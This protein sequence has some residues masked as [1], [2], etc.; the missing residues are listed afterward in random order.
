MKGSFQEEGMC[1]GT[2]AA[3]AV[4]RRRHRMNSSSIKKYGD[5]IKIR[6]TLMNHPQYRLGI[7]VQAVILLIA[8][9]NISVVVV[10]QEEIT[11]TSSPT[12]KITT[13]QSISPISP[14]TTL[15][16][17]LPVTTSPI[18]SES[19]MTTSP[20]ISPSLPPA[21]LVSSID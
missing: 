7:I 1:G 4:R 12:P 19:P 14:S 17:F 15:A 16:P 9:T 18:V 8:I 21:P 5:R 6:Y 11:T 10:A 13:D 3:A 2:W 20:T